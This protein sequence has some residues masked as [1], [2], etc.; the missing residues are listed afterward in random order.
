MCP[1]RLCHNISVSVIF[2]IICRMADDAAT[3]VA[4]LATPYRT[5]GRLKKDSKKN[6]NR[7][8]K[9]ESI[10]LRDSDL[11]H[12]RSGGLQRPFCRAQGTD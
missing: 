9:A 5:E 3:V 10:A 12:G 11:Y 6:S 8:F 2:F 1:A 4:L 7:R